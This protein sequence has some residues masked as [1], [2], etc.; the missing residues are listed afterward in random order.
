MPESLND[1][2]RSFALFEKAALQYESRLILKDNKKW[3]E[4]F[5][6]LSPAGEASTAVSPTQEKGFDALG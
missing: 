2:R 3:L 4:W 5:L 6:K 1:S